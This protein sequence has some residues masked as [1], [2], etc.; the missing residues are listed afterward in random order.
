MIN[1]FV[2]HIALFI[3]APGH[4]R[5]LFFLKLIIH[6]KLYHIIYYCKCWNSKQHSYNSE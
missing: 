5:K 1:A 3:I 2:I 6:Q 4:C